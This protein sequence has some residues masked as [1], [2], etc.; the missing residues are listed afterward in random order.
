MTITTTIYL[1]LNSV[2]N[3]HI[4]SETLFSYN[5]QNISDLPSGNIGKETSTKTMYNHF[6][7]GNIQPFN[8]KVLHLNNKQEPLVIYGI[9]S[10]SLHLLNMYECTFP[11]VNCII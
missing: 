11:V 3:R 8:R 2:D 1:P 7:P 4:F 9:I 5:E 10:S 6:I